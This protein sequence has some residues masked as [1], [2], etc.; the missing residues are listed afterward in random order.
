MCLY[1]DDYQDLMG[2]LH[3]FIT[4]S[5]AGIKWAKLHADR[6]QH[7]PMAQKTDSSI[8]LEQCLFI[9]YKDATMAVGEKG[10]LQFHIDSP[11]E[12]K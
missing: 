3:P 4:D 2:A 12:M 1:R 11:K 5:L 10:T 6:L 7:D 9:H 8:H